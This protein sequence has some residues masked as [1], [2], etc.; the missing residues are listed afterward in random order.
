MLISLDVL[1][2]P[3]DAAGVRALLVSRCPHRPQA[4]QQ[5]QH[6]APASQA[7]LGPPRG[8]SCH[9]SFAGTCMGTRLLASATGASRRHGT[10]HHGPCPEL[11][12]ALGA[13]ERSSSRCV[14]LPF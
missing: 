14:H 13:E 6:S 8:R 11:P 10:S 1:A 12:L 4:P 2:V 9:L 3:Q 7:H 5:S